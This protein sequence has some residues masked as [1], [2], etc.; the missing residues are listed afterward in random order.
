[1]TVLLT[2]SVRCDEYNIFKTN[3]PSRKLSSLRSLLVLESS[4]MAISLSSSTDGHHKVALVDV[5]LLDNF[6]PGEFVL[7]MLYSA[8]LTPAV[9]GTV[10]IS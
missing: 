5:K 9:S 4:A 1:M 10:I 7:E 6:L 3:S 8:H 2:A